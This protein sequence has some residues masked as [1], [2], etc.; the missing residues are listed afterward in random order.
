[1][2]SEEENKEILINAISPFFNISEE[3]WGKHVYGDNVRIDMIVQPKRHDQ[4][5]S[6]KNTLLGIEVKPDYDNFNHITGL[7]VQAIDYRNS[8]WRLKGGDFKHIPIFLYPNPL[9][10]PKIDAYFLERF[11][12]RMNIGVIEYLDYKECFEFR[13]SA[14]PIF[15]TVEGA[16]KKAMNFKFETTFGRQ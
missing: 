11:L 12:G 2:K 14:C 4:W 5:R 16:K 13:M 7:L 9:S 8:K 1:M 15:D 3:R 6:G 10:H